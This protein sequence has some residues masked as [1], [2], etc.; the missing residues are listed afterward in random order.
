MRIS[1]RSRYTKALACDSAPQ[2]LRRSRGL[3]FQPWLSDRKHLLCVRQQKLGPYM[4][5]ALATH[6][7]SDEGV[8][9]ALTGNSPDLQP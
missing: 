3:S 4:D 6:S 5:L 2:N 1:A 8:R 7:S 9:V